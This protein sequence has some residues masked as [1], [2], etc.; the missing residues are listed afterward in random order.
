MTAS[1][2]NLSRSVHF[3]GVYG[4]GWIF[5]KPLKKA[6]IAE[7]FKPSKAVRS[8]SRQQL[9]CQKKRDHHGFWDLKWVL[10]DF[11]WPCV[12]GWG[13]WVC[14]VWR[15]GWWGQQRHCNA[16]WWWCKRLC[17]RVGLVWGV[18][19]VDS[20]VYLSGKAHQGYT[21]QAPNCGVVVVLL[22]LM[23]QGPLGLH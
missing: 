13:C 15:G 5:M 6:G 21:R 17:G 18:A 14:W 11:C 4:Q 9:S 10:V 7:S 3:S 23:W 22:L 2:D 8:K 1:E 12:V 16:W 20:G 19:V